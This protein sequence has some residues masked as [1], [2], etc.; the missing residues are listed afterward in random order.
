MGA[1]RYTMASVRGRC[2][3]YP[4]TLL[5]ALAMNP[6]PSHVLRH[7]I[8]GIRTIGRHVESAGGQTPQHRSRRCR[9]P[10]SASQ[11]WLLEGVHGRSFRSRSSPSPSP[12]LRSPSSA[13]TSHQTQNSLQITSG[14]MRNLIFKQNSQESFD[15]AIAGRTQDYYTVGILCLGW[16]RLSSWPTPGFIMIPV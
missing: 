7:L 8:Q 2:M 15:I 13:R 11:R 16:V 12:R 4:H 6:G 9:R 5:A 1:G 14:I 10:N 3:G